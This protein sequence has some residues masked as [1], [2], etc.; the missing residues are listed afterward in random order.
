[1]VER[2]LLFINNKR[3]PFHLYALELFQ[4]LRKKHITKDASKAFIQDIIRV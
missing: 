2:G 1:M 4:E 3:L